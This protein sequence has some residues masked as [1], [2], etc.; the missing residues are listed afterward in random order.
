VYWSVP[1]NGTTQREAILKLLTAARGQEVSL[2]QILGLKISQFGAR[3]LELRRQGYVIKNRIAHEDGKVLS[4]YRLEGKKETP[5]PPSTNAIIL[6]RQDAA[7]L[8][9]KDSFPEFGAIAPE[10]YPD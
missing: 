3:I 5:A 6:Q 9:T 10:R 7:R 8:A 1:V 2:P 4:W